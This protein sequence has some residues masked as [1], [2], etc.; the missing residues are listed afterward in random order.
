MSNKTFAVLGMG[1][2]GMG[3]ALELS[4]LGAQVMVADHNEDLI[5]QVKDQVERA[6]LCDLSDPMSL[7]KLGLAQMDTVLV[8]M[9][10]NLESS[11][12]CCMIAKESG[13][14]RIVAKA[15]NVRMGDILTR[16]G[17]DEIIYPEE[18]SAKR[19]AIRLYSNEIRDFFNIQDALSLIE[20]VPRSAWV[21]HSLLELELRKKYGINVIGIKVKGKIMGN[22]DPNRLIEKDDT[23]L[24]IMNKSDVS[25]V[26]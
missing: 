20:V 17:A 22:P 7:K 12:M 21:N 3:I 14:G 4:K 11:I 15:R 25:K 26:F 16:V 23:L 19:N 18:E 10:S 13:V 9:A 5:D 2:F 8:T 1:R 24:I 6:V